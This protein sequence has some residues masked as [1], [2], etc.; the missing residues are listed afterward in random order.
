MAKSDGRQRLSPG[1]LDVMRELWRGG[2]LTVNEVH[3]AVNERLKKK[4]NRNTIL[5]QL[6]RVENKGWIDHERV[7]RA[8]Y[9]YPVVS[10]EQAAAELTRDFRQR[11]FDGSAV[12]LVKC[13]FQDGALD[14]GEIEELQAL[15]DEKT[16]KDKQ[17][18]KKKG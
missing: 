12:D 10:Y 8:Y 5:V 1:E 4:L 14:G 16:G 15:I 3:A 6:Q 17:R 13:L 18:P 2:R 11:M 9:Y 7:G